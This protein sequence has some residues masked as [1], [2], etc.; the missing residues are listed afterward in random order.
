MALQLD[1]ERRV[2]PVDPR[3]SVKS[4][5]GWGQKA[6]TGRPDAERRA[7][8]MGSVAAAVLIGEE[9]F[10]L[11]PDRPFVFGRG[12]ADDI[13][14]L[15][16]T[17]MG[18]SAVAG[19]VESAWGLWWVV[20]RSAKRPL[21]LDDV[22]GGTPRRLGCGLRYAVCVSRL[23]VLIPG[24]IYTHRLE[25]VVPTADLARFHGTRSSSG[26]VTGGEV[27]L[28]ERDR[29][30]VVAL[31][32][33][34]LEDFPRRQ[35]RPRTYQQAAELLG[36]SWTKI[37]VRKQIERLKLRLTAAGLYFDGP[38][39]NFDLADHLIG[40]GLLCP[41]DLARLPAGR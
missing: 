11:S 15:D 33:G 24:V 5:L 22:G 3:D 41:A 14:G 6:R 9:E 21:L 38:Q 36:P 16:P 10:G 19:S 7:E 13:L 18:I 20:N 12:D 29:D 27:R 17:D 23:S 26:T 30:V 34:Y 32:S 40:D 2:H 28:S 1:S 4:G 37:T 39:A 31:L 35:A 25:V 8:R